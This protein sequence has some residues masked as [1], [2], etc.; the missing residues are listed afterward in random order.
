MKRTTLS[1]FAVTAALAAVTG[2]ATATLPEETGAGAAPVAERLPVERSG[3]LCP[4]PGDSGPARTAHT[5]YTPGTE[6]A[7]DGGRARLSPA[8][9]KSGGPGKPGDRP[10]PVLAPKAPGTPVTAVTSD[11]DAPALI[12][13][14]EG[15][16]APGWTVQQTT[17]VPG[18]EGRGLLGLTCAAPDTEFW[19]P[20]AS[21]AKDR[22][23]YVHL[24]NPDDAAA[25]VDIE[26][27][28]RGGA[29]VS[30]LGEGIQVRPRAS[31]PVLLSTLTDEPQGD[32]TVHVTVRSGRVAAAVR[33]THARHG[34]DWLPP[35][36]DPAPAVVVPGVPDDVTAAR[37][38][39]FAPGD[40]DAE[41]SV[42]IASPNGPITPAGNESLH[43]KAGMTA[44][45]DLGDLTRGEAGSLLL[46][47][48]DRTS[49]PVVA[50]LR[51]VRGEGARAETA[52]IPAST[53]VG[54]RA[55]AADNRA[56][57]TSL[58]LTAPGEDAR[59]RV[60]ASAGSRGGTPVT[61]TFTVRGGT[62]LA[63]GPLVPEGLKGTYAL[64]VETLSGGPVHAA[65]TLEVPG[66]GVPMFTVQTLSDDR[67][68][69]LVPEAEED[70][71]ILQR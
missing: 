62:T 22:T 67:S 15:R 16:L 51:V 35:S 27:Y 14:A 23:D 4:A 44:A 53:A 54:R 7:P 17:V 60:T 64:T 33:A 5:S 1:L 68:T 25:V 42:R 8:D 55:T 41:L 65:R 71:S 18:G 69:V 21:T 46:T 58:A 32:L 26:L 28:G 48:K 52:F 45:V 47:P 36:A 24:T 40:Q 9:P 2:L 10:A 63:T 49:A 70:L 39:V 6:G 59:V 13:A 50:A 11:A 57:G 43:V 56:K 3:A 37:L 34:A 66:G 61:K 12:G 19:L 29:L 30:A 38:V 20:G 31:V